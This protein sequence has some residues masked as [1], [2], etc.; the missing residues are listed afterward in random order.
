[1]DL[2]QGLSRQLRKFIYEKGWRDFTP[3]QKGALKYSKASNDNLILVAPTASGKT[4]AAFL[5]AIDSSLGKEG[6]KI[7]YIPSY[8]LNKRP[9]SKD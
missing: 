4:E 3:I 5:P 9:V 6:L 1:M 8:R 7:I 2:Y